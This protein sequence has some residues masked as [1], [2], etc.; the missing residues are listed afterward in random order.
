MRKHASLTTSTL[1][2]SLLFLTGCASVGFG[3]PAPVGPTLPQGQEWSLVWSDEFN[4]GAVDGA[5]WEVVGDSKRRDGYWVR[6]DTY[7]DGKGHLVLRTKK[8]GDRYTSGAIRT[9]G[10]F[11]RAFGY[12]EV[13]CKF[14]VEVGHWPAFW[15]M[16]GGVGKVGDGGRDG[17]EIDIMEKPW[18]DERV[19][20]ALHWDGYGDHHQSKGEVAKVP[21]VMEG[22]HTFGLHWTPEE[23]VFYIDGKETWRTNAGGVCQVPVYL[24]L[25]EEIGDWGGDIKEAALPDYFV[26]DYVRVYEAVQGKK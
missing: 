22:F 24:K 13:R 26:V 7:V 11:E 14:P 2:L 16:C 9:M 25:T 6:E 18:R 1:I 12:Y 3:K 5:K 20:H 10:R 21:G 17:T 4:G 15:M 8:D 23:Y 19:Q